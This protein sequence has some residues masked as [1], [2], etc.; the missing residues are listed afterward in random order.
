MNADFVSQDFCPCNF[1]SR[2]VLNLIQ[3]QVDYKRKGLSMYQYLMDSF[4]FMNFPRNPNFMFGIS[5]NHRSYCNTA[6]LPLVDL[7]VS[8]GL[9]ASSLT[10]SGYIISFFESVL[11]IPISH[12][13]SCPLCWGGESLFQTCLWV[14]TLHICSHPEHDLLLGCSPWGI[15]GSLPWDA[16]L[17]DVKRSPG[18]SDYRWHLGSGQGF[19]HLLGSRSPSCGKMLSVSPMV[20]H[21]HF[22]MK[23][24]K[25]MFRMFLNRD[26]QERKIRSWYKWLVGNKLEGVSVFFLHS[27]IVW[28]SRKSRSREYLWFL[29][30][31]CQS[32]PDLDPSHFN[33]LRVGSFWRFFRLWSCIS[34]MVWN[35]CVPTGIAHYQ[36]EHTR[37]SYMNISL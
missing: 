17:V 36:Y 8:R 1:V 7:L 16:N 24:G 6:K 31:D 9:L 33:I 22:I 13:N 29:A 23:H 5:K 10:F 2:P 18:C 3:D 27:Q 4:K 25:L 20:R 21:Q 12:S 26:E 19:R 30:S 11:L 15:L 32:C 34:G 35:S 28:V 14:K 37:V